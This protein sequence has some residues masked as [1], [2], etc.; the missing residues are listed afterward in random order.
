PPAVAREQMRKAHLAVDKALQLAPGMGQA[1]AVRAHLHFYNFEHREAL[2]ECRRAA[3]LAPDDGTVLFGCGYT[4]T[5]IGK[6]GE[7]MRLREHLLVIEP[8]YN[9]NVS[10]YAGLL[11]ATGRLD[12]ATNYLHM[13][14]SLSPPASPPLLWSFY[15]AI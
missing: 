15:I 2:A 5:G 7:A 8:L 14:Q 13:A 10:D 6:L 3:K 4:L 12:E 1:H 9:V 11:M